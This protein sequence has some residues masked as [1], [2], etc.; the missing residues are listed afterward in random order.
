M[1]WYWW[2]LIAILG[3]N[4]FAIA[5]LG[6]MMVGDWVTQ[7]RMKKCEGRPPRDDSSGDQGD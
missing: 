6:F 3:L 2:I 5:M 4:A 1:A 7:R